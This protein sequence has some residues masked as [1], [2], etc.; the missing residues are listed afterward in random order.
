MLATW[1]YIQEVCAV[2]AHSG[3]TSADHHQASADRRY[4]PINSV[5]IIN[6]EITELLILYCGGE[7][8]SS[9]SSAGTSNKSK[10]KIRNTQR[11]EIVGTDMGTKDRY[12]NVKNKFVLW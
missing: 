2:R 6:L 12:I 3:V 11:R 9:M 10:D 1:H 7:S 4:M 5:T 8:S